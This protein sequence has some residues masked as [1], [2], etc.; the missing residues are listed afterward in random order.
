VKLRR[1]ARNLKQKALSSLRRGLL[2]FNAYDDDGRITTVLLHFQHCCEM[3]TKAA[4]VQQRVN[5]FDASGRTFSL[6]KCANL[7]KQ[8]CGI[9]EGEAGLM[10]AVDSLRNAEQHWFL[11]IDED[12]LYL[13][14]RGVVTAVDDILKRSFEDDLSRHLPARVLPV[15]TQPPSDIDFIVD[16]EFRKIGELLAPGRRARDEARGRIR[17]LLAMESHTTEEVA[18]SEKDI[19]RIEKAIRAGKQV[20]QVF[21]RLGTLATTR[22]GDGINVTVHFTKKQG[23]PVRFVSGDDIEEAGAI[24]ELDLSRKYYLPAT[25]LAEKIGLTGPRSTALRRHLGI[26]T[27][28]DCAHEFVF[29]KSRFLQFSDNAA[30][31]MKEAAEAED[32]DAIWKAYRNQAGGGRSKVK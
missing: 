19:T 24:R 26:D 11:R 30:R 20:G 29:G 21:P 27:D 14:A 25:K 10:R 8:H 15:S 23:A 2:A 5:I 1:E 32:M 12:V 17:A 6:E 4:L 22:G 9:T 31:K 16:R 13:H 7:A 3:L 18:V 28:K